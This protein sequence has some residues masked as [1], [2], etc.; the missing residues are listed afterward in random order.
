[1]KIQE[2]L[3]FFHL[4][5]F[6][7][8]VRFLRIVMTFPC[9]LQL[10]FLEFIIDKTAHTFPPHC[11][12][13]GNMLKKNMKPLYFE[14]SWCDVR[15]SFNSKDPWPSLFTGVNVWVYVFVPLY[16]PLRRMLHK[17]LLVCVLC[18]HIIHKNGFKC[19]RTRLVRLRKGCLPLYTSYVTIYIVVSLHSGVIVVVTIFLENRILG[20]RT[21]F[22]ELFSQHNLSMS[23]LGSVRVCECVRR[24]KI[25]DFIHPLRRIRRI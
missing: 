23:V 10:N 5:A 16:F 17:C 8:K 7:L 15:F 20:A 2:I 14:P 22:T 11:C 25:I 19:E 21:V 13:F 18:Q 6:L 12:S 3:I 1:M 9:S 4:N 24:C